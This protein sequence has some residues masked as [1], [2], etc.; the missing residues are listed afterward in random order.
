[1]I[2]HSLRLLYLHPSKTGGTSIE[3]GLLEHEL[4]EVVEWSDDEFY[5]AHPHRA[6][7]YAMWETEG[8]THWDYAKL[9]SEFPFLSDWDS[10]MTT[11]NPYDRAISE[12]RYQ[13]DG[14]RTKTTKFHDSDDINGAIKSGA[15]QEAQYAYH[16]WPQHNYVG[17]N[18]KIIPMEDINQE[19]ENM[20]FEPL[21]PLNISTNKREYILDDDSVE[22]IYRRFEQD[23]KDF[24]YSP[25]YK[26][27]P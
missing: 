6:R 24:N 27:K 1:M 5:R 10:F 4:G 20:G 22:I 9:I 26:L 23:F 18:T 11:R 3:G 7:M 12:W 17:H 21:K 19:W 16:W 15:M 13:Q 2:A 8:M 25:E 14:N